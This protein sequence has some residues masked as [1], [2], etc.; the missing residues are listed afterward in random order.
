MSTI[1][2]TGASGFLGQHLVRH[3]SKQG[4]NVRALYFQNAPSDALMHL[5]NVTWQQCDL[6]D[7]FDVA[8]AV[9]GID[10]L[11][12]CAAIV[13]FHAANKEKM[14]HF[15]IESTVNIVNEALEHDIRKLVF[16]SSVAALGRSE[17][18]KKEITEEEQW[19]ES[20]Y[21]SRYGLSKH[22][23]E[24]EVWRGA[25]EGLNAVV[26]N[27]GIIL[28]SGD[29]NEGSA[30]LIKVV[31]DEFPFYTEGVNAWVDV[32]D[33]VNAMTQL[34]ASD[35]QDQRFILSAGNFSYKE[36][37]TQMAQALGKR[38][39][40]IKAGK[41][42]TSLVWRWA[43]L[44]SKLIGKTATVTRET[45]ATAQKKAYYNNTKLSDY[46]PGFQYTDLKTTIQRM[47]KAFIEE[48]PQKP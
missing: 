48:H 23:A 36:V 47:A 34:M 18:G 35:I 17:A 20:R 32:Q 31:N 10:E 22:L 14:L 26:V 5:P 12:H 8:A 37:F 33:V 27:P 38:P 46:L 30:R 11:Y 42:L 21:N 3:L 25:G 40:H 15:N 28:G 16:V 44:R 41:L 45:A 19:E 4:R 1:L 9:E 2:V 29:W 13:S 43:S 24:L 6:L 39:P 7:V